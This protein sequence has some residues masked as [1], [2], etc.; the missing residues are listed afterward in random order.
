MARSKASDALTSQRTPT[1]C[2]AADVYGGDTTDSDYCTYP[3]LWLRIQ[4]QGDKFMSYFATA[5]TTDIPSG[6]SPGSTNGWQLLTVIN[7]FTTNGAVAF[8][9]TVYFGLR[10][11]GAHNSDISDTTHTVTATY[12][13]YGPTP[14]PPSTPSSG[15]VPVPAAKAPG[16]FPNQSVRGVN[17]HV[18]LPANGQ[19]YPGDIVQS[20]QGTPS[21]IIWNSGGAMS[22]SRDEIVDFN[23]EETPDGFSSARYHAGTFDFAISPRDP[24]IAQQNLG[25]YSNPNRERFNTGSIDVPIE[26]YAPSP[27]YG[28]AIS[29]VRKNGQ[30]WNDTSPYFYG[31]TYMQ[32]DGVST[33]QAY[34]MM[35]GHFR[36][37]QFYTRTTKLVTGLPT[38]PS[39]DLGPIPRC[40]LHLDRL[41]SL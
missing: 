20:S 2:R 41:V 22:V 5:N 39:S 13:N 27:N 23:T 38:D 14:T 7:S 15:G 37:G 30:Q 17:W 36:G 32:L 28:F 31:A 9:K 24:S 29:T 21:Q 19:G 3:D 11:R 25:P 6:I 4:R 12:D 10:T 33:G 1:T 34:D 35:A 18:S 8:P 16:P 26:V 40:G